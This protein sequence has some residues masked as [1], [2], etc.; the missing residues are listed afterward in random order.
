MA[1]NQYKTV[2]SEEEK[3]QEIAQCDCSICEDGDYRFSRYCLN[4]ESDRQLI[5]REGGVVN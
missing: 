4:K 5:L 2:E 3:P 1:K